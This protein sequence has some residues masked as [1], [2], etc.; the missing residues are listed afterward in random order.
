M[1]K[2][3]KF[4]MVFV[5]LSACSGGTSTTVESEVVESGS[6][7]NSSSEASNVVPN[8]SGSDQAAQAKPDYN[9]SGKQLAWN[10]VGQNALKN[11]LKDPES[12][13]FRNVEFYSGGSVPVTCGEVNARNSFGGYSGFERFIAAGS[14]LQVLESEMAAG[15]MSKVW[16]QLC[17]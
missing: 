5:V 17:R 14:Q 2:S 13:T 10:E 3:S 16:A 1:L 11:K 12:A 6:S 15:E 7:E 8:S 4:L 9:D